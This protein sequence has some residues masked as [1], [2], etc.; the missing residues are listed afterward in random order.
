MMQAF[1]GTL[2]EGIEAVVASHQQEAEE[3]RWKQAQV[4]MEHQELRRQYGDQASELTAF[5][6]GKHNF[7]SMSCNAAGIPASSGEPDGC[8]RTAPALD[9]SK[10]ATTWAMVVQRPPR[11]PSHEAPRLHNRGG[12]SAPVEDVVVGCVPCT[13]HTP[14][15]ESRMHPG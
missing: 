8:M 1:R 5:W 2:R 9:M 6:E 15:A 11:Q 14:V 3:L 7:P 4:E 12:A 13:Q 10:G